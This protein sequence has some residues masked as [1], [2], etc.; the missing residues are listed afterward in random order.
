MSPSAG[1]RLRRAREPGED[2][3]SLLLDLRRAARCQAFATP[4]TT[5]GQDGMPL[6]G[7]GGKYVPAKYGTPSGVRNA[8]SGQPPRPVIAC[9]ASM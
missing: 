7:S 1:G 6:R 9:T 4:I 2:L 8:F 3:P 5:C